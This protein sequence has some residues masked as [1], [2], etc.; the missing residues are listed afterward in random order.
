MTINANGYKVNNV[1]EYAM[2]C[3]YIV[4]RNC[5]DSMWF[6]GAWNNMEIA[7]KTARENGGILIQIKE[8]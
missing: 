1:P 8:D 3:K 5:N 4:A 2:D 7:K 6:Y